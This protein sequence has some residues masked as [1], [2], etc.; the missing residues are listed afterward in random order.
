MSVL[1]LSGLRSVLETNDDDDDEVDSGSTN[2]PDSR[3][4]I[5]ISTN[6]PFYFDTHKES[7]ADTLP[8]ETL[9]KVLSMYKTSVDAVSKCTHYSTLQSSI[10]TESSYLGYTTRSFAFKALK[11]AVVYVTLCS[12]TDVQSLETFGEEKG[13]L[14]ELWRPETEHWL[15]AADMTRNHNIVVIQALIL[16]VVCLSK[17]TI[18]SGTANLKLKGCDSDT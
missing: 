11:S 1:Q 7:I 6:S 15:R 10:E 14:R 5:V 13:K 2:L 4:E 3:E 9:S 12:M 16:Y 8:S 18:F 17:N